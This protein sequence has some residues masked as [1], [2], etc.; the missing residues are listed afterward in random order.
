V[1]TAGRNRAVNPRSYCTR[2]NP[3]TAKT[4]V[5][6]PLSHR[7]LVTVVCNLAAKPWHVPAS[8]DAR[9]LVL[10]SQPAVRMATTRV[11]LPADAVAVLASER[12]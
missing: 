3:L 8:T 1:A 4:R 12:S 11:T 5:R 7:G 6:I 9:L 2:R 10:A